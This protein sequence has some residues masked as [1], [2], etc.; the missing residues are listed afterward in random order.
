M[1][2]GFSAL[3]GIG[4]IRFPG[5]LRRLPQSM[6]NTSSVHSTFV[7][8]M[9]PVMSPR[10]FQNQSPNK[11]ACGIDHGFKQMIESNQPSDL[12]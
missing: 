8:I 11:T 4:A 10:Y 9:A 5:I 1:A 6:L 12:I 2:L 7:A 3:F